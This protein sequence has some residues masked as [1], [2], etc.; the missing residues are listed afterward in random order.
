MHVTPSGYCAG[1]CVK[2]VLDSSQNNYWSRYYNKV[3]LTIISF[4]NEK[5][6][7]SIRPTFNPS[8][9]LEY[10]TS[11]CQAREEQKGKQ[12]KQIGGR[13]FISLSS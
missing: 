11:G 10:K 12:I 6:F 5:W 7:A 13:L 4:H 1:K 3:D 2:F 9:I 8:N